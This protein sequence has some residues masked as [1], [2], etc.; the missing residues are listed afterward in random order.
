LGWPYAILSDIAEISSGG[1]VVFLTVSH[2]PNAAI[3]LCTLIFELGEE[4][5]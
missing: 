2:C 5:R 4:V 3:L 1:R